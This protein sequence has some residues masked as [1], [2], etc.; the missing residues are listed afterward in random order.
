[1]AA[2]NGRGYAGGEFNN[3][4]TA[5]ASPGT[6]L[7]PRKNLLAFNLSTGVLD[8]GFRADANGRVWDLTVTDDGRYLLVAGEF[9]AING[10]ARAGFAVL[11]ART[12]A[13]VDI[14]VRLAGTARAVATCG[15]TAYVGGM[16]TSAQGQARNG[17]AAVD[18]TTGKVLPFNANIPG[19]AVLT[20]VAS[21]DGRRLA[22]GGQFTAIGSQSSGG[23]VLVDASTGA[24]RNTPISHV[25]QTGGERSGVFGLSADSRGFYVAGWK[26]NVLRGFEGVAAADWDG[27]LRWIADCHGD[28]ED[29][30]VSGDE[31]HAVGHPHSCATVGGHPESQPEQYDAMV[32]FTNSVQGTTT[33]T[34]WPTSYANY[35]GLPA[36][37]LTAHNPQVAAGPSDGHPTHAIAG[38]GDYMVIGGEFPQVQRQPQQGI[39]RF[40]RRPVAPGRQAPEYQELGLRVQQVGPGRVQVLV[41]PT[42]DRD[43]VTLT[44]RLTRAGRLVDERR[45][46]SGKWARADYAL[47]EEVPAGQVTYSITVTDGSGNSVVQQASAQVGTTPKVGEYATLVHSDGARQIWGAAPTGSASA[48]SGTSGEGALTLSGGAAKTGGILGEA[49]NLSASAAVA[50]SG[51][52]VPG[53][54]DVSVEAWVYAAPGARSGRIIGLSA[55]PTAQNAY[56]DH[57]LYLDNGGACA[58]VRGPRRRRLR[59][60]RP[61]RSRT[62]GG[63]TSSAPWMRSARTAC[64]WTAWRWRARPG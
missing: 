36:P 41:T 44:Y 43:D 63:T 6:Q 60:L 9:T 30:W 3:A 11:D 32:S 40:G 64:S 57:L 22:V 5:G 59:S 42:W 56:N 46:T 54:Y 45:I 39:A 35:G 27:N 53:R 16:F 33:P 52:K 20:M 24:I 2:K 38:E 34:S 61:G 17:I 47:I 37:R 49:L 7:S 18:L 48:L 25:L 55:H 8:P 50:W 58:S 12:G 4:R 14:D 31:V 10:Q 29:V 51:E 15:S 28:T 62:A 13:V 1:M 21:P 19:H 23:V 26:Y